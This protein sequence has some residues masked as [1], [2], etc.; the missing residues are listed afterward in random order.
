MIAFLASIGAN[1]LGLMSAIG[2]LALF[3]GQTLGHLVRPPF[4]A[5]E[6]GHALVL[7]G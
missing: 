3:T 4:Y 1:A 2:R 5:R 7:I 6:F